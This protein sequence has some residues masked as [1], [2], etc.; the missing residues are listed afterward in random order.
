MAFKCIIIRCSLGKDPK[1][2]TEVEQVDLKD[3]TR[4]GDHFIGLH[5]GN[6]KADQTVKEILAPRFYKDT[7]R[8]K[9]GLDTANR[10]SERSEKEQTGVAGGQHGQHGQWEQNDDACNEEMR[11]RVAGCSTIRRLAQGRKL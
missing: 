3:F 8:Q 2:D 5:V 4:V 11:D 1:A 9:A 10:T 7:G 6:Q